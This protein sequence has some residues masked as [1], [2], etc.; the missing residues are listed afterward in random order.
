MNSVN[1]TGRLTA[2]IDL[3]TSLNGASVCN[4]A[5]AVKRPNVKDV[6]DFINCVAWRNT[7]DFIAKY[8]SKG[9]KI[10]VNGVLTARQYQDK[11]GNKHIATEVLVENVDFGERKR[12]NKDNESNA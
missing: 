8:F 1:L 10:E 9:D 11:N 7:A 12:E 2:D 3:K 6:T 5:I 4:F